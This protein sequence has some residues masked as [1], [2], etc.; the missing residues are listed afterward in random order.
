MPQFNLKINS[1][2]F[3]SQIN[4]LNEPESCQYA[5]HTYKEASG[6]TATGWEQSARQRGHRW[7]SWCF[8]NMDYSAATKNNV[9]LSSL[10]H[11]TAVLSGNRCNV[12]KPAKRDAL[13]KDEPEIL[14]TYP[15]SQARRRTE[16]PTVTRG[17]T[18]LTF[19][20]WFIFV[21]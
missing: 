8:H 10:G 9:R 11:A 15:V 7:I 2:P 3:S 21:I 4:C 17:R 13:S 18:A 19:L 16:G 6:S 20:S 5:E 14:C 1:S 12:E